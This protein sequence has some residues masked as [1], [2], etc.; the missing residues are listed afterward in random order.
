[1]MKLSEFKKGEQFFFYDKLWFCTD[2]GSRVVTGIAMTELEGRVETPPYSVPEIVLDEY[3]QE[4]CYIN[5]ADYY[6]EFG[7]KLWVDDQA[8]EEDMESFRSPPPDDLSWQVAKTSAQAIELI[9]AWGPPK[10]ISFDHDLGLL[11]DGTEDT[12]M[13]VINYLIEHHYAA[14]IDYEVHSKNGPGALNIRSKMN[15]WKRSQSL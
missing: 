8:L 10:Y 15:S 5:L 13:T 4:V 14:E 1:M 2:V 6:K 12:A 3:D 9:Q 11:P 7:F